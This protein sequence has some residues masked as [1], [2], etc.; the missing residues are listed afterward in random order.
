MRTLVL[1]SAFAASFGLTAPLAA[2]DRETKVRND[3]KNVEEAGRWIYNDL[4]KGIAE[5][6]KTGKPLLVIFRCLLLTEAGCGY[7]Y[8][9]RFPKPVQC[10]LYQN[11]FEQI[12][13]PYFFY[14]PKMNLID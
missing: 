11:D 8:N 14:Y 4:P 6:K 1:V 9:E 13:P 3:R 2:Q 12:P 5:A 10:F 7:R